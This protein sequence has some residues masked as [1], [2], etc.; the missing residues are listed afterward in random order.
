[1]TNTTQPALSHDSAASPFTPEACAFS[2]AQWLTWCRANLP[3][4]EPLVRSLKIIRHVQ[5]IESGSQLVRLLFAYVVNNLSL[6]T[7]SA[8]AKAAMDLRIGDEGLREKFAASE[9]LLVALLIDTMGKL[10][11]R[12]RFDGAADVRLHDG[13]M[14]CSIGKA[15]IR[16]RIHGTFSL[17]GTSPVGLEL[18]T[19]K[20][21]E[22]LAHAVADPGD[23]VATDRGY[24]RPRAVIAAI[25]A[26]QDLLM[27][28]QLQLLPPKDAAASDLDLRDLV[29]RAKN[30][31]LDT[32]IVIAAEGL[33]SRPIR[34]VMA[35]MSSEAAARSVQKL[36]A[37]ASR[38][39]RTPTKTSLMLAQ[40]FAL[41]TTW[42]RE[43]VP[44]A[45]VLTA[46]SARWQVELFF[47]RC[48]SL[49]HLA[50]DKQVKE[51]MAKV[52]VLTHLLLIA[53]T[54]LRR[55]QELVPWATMTNRGPVS[56]WQVTQLLW[57]GWAALVYGF[58]ADA[59]LR[60]VLDRLRPRSRRTRTYALNKIGQLL[61]LVRSQPAPERGKTP[62]NA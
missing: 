18:T 55:P 37:A 19:E 33:G 31:V 23:T 9:P 60:T 26:R 42:S 4:L 43:K 16:L 35:K 49:T 62:A 48:K 56:L 22:T 47:K 11:A 17:G 25:D 13:S 30:G 27:R 7:T 50:V 8:F 41:V 20:D 61:A 3:Q 29:R 45:A 53:L 51:P 36:R 57:T 59:D 28:A 24:A 6:A 21:G 46:Y 32:E 14:V 58:L 5:A 39:G 10:S 34:L 40:Y 54:E 2:E 15:R 38:K 12:C 1:M 44:A 52:I